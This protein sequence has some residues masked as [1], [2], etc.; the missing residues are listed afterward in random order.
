M[1]LSHWFCTSKRGTVYSLWSTSHS[2]GEGITYT[3]TAFVVSQTSWR[4]GFGV[5]GALCV[6][7]AFW[8]YR[9]LSDH[10]RTYGL[11]SY[12][13][14]KKSKGVENPLTVGQQQLQV[15]KKPAIIVIGMSSAAMYFSRYAFLDWGPFFLEKFKGY[16]YE[17]ANGFIGVS[18]IVGGLLGTMTPGWLSDKLFHSNR[19]I[20]T[21]VFGLI[22]VLGISLLMLM[23]PVYWADISYAILFA[24]G[25][26]GLLVLL[27]GLIAIDFASPRAVGAAMGFIGIFS[28]MAGSASQDLINGFLIQSTMV[29]GKEVYNFDK[30]VVG[31]WIGAAVLSMLLAASVFFVRYLYEKKQNR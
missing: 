16:S 9:M 29:D 8:M 11:K 28:Y 10:P 14:D 18:T 13:E 26:G 25:T 12:N 23:P 20:V 2:I 3:A 22:Q 31:I 15:L 1:S 19:G 5:S 7:A 24:F 30:S 17:T 6:V 21:F 4:W 27:G